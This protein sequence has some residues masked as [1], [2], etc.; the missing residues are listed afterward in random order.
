MSERTTK[1]SE[2][3]AAQ[4]AKNAAKMFFSLGRRKDAR[5]T[6]LVAEKMREEYLIDYVADDIVTLLPALSTIIQADLI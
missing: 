5:G 1:I 4:E 6:V 2:F 3:G